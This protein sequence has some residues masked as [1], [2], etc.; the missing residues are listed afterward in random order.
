MEE[1]RAPR[2]DNEITYNTI[3]EITYNATLPPSL[4]VT[5]QGMSCG[6]KYTHHT[7]TPIIKQQI[8]TT[9]ANTGIKVIDE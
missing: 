5:A 3:N 9:T 2:L 7:F 4:D 1:L 8:T 6:A